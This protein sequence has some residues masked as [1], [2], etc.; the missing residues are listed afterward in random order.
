MEGDTGSGAARPDEWG[1]AVLSGDATKLA[2]LVLLWSGSKPE[3][4][5]SILR[6]CVSLLENQMAL[7]GPVSSPPSSPRLHSHG[8]WGLAVTSRDTTKLPELVLVWSDS[9]PERALSFLR[10]CV[11]LME[12]EVAL[13]PLPSPPIT[14]GELFVDVWSKLSTSTPIELKRCRKSC[15]AVGWK[16][17]LVQYR[18]S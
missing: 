12:K 6:D 16:V 4:A 15:L 13:S 10:S 3:L 18:P 2:E 11:S 17:F 9:E 5:L 14:P 7:S 8:E 1:S